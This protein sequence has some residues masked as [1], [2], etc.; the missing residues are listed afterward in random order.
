[1]RF[2]L[3]N[4]KAY[5]KLGYSLIEVLAALA[6]NDFA[7]GIEYFQLFTMLVIASSRYSE[8]GVFQQSNELPKLHSLRNRCLGIHFLDRSAVPAVVIF[9]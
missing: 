7:D 8:K 6:S 5:E 2:H 3:P 4:F 9:M 1:M